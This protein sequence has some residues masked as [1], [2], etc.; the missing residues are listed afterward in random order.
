MTCLHKWF[1]PHS[2]TPVD[3]VGDVLSLG[4]HSEGRKK[5]CTKCGTVNASTKGRL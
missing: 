5:I 1:D 4:V 3:F 2:Y